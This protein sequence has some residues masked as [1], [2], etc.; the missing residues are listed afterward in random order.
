MRTLLSLTDKKQ[1]KAITPTQR[2]GAGARET[3]PPPF[4]VDKYY[5]ADGVLNAVKMEAESNKKMD[6]RAL[7]GD[8]ASRDDRRRSGSGGRRGYRER[9]MAILS[10]ADDIPMNLQLA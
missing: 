10:S 3:V 1:K 5:G 9:L 4:L 7:S 8:G 6:L 2:A